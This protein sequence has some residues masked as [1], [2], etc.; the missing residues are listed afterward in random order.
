MIPKNNTYREDTLN[1]REILK[2]KL[3]RDT[4]KEI[5]AGFGD[6]ERK[7]QL[8]QISQRAVQPRVT[9]GMEVPEVMSNRNYLIDSI[10]KQYL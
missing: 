9:A 10:N 3:K 1:L 4:Q 2:E 7:L 8:N 5:G 6:I